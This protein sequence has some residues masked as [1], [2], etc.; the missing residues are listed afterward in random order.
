[1]RF[2]TLAAALVRPP[3][4]LLTIPVHV[5][6]NPKYLVP[7]STQA[8]GRINTEFLL[9][10]PSKTQLLLDRLANRY[11]TVMRPLFAAPNG[12]GHKTHLCP[13]PL[14]LYLFTL[15]LFAEHLPLHLLNLPN[16]PLELRAYRTTD[17]KLNPSKA[18]IVPHLTIPHKIML[19]PGCI[20]A[21]SDLLHPLRQTPQ[22]LPEHPQLLKSRRDI[23]ISKLRVH[24]HPLLSPPGAQRLVCL[25][26]IITIKRILLVRLHQRGI[27]IQCGYILPLVPLH[28]GEKIL[29]HLP[30]TPQMPIGSR[31]KGFALLP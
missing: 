17:G 15:R 28:K 20:R 13:L 21:H 8:H 7:D 9:F 10:H 31:Y 25:V 30:K 29:V 1:M 27:H 23:A 6:H 5:G 3:D 11:V 12:I 22:R 19:I 18:L 24:H 14:R 16:C 4:Q 2:L 26:S